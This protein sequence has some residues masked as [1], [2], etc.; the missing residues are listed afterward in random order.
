MACDLV[1]PLRSALVDALLLGKLGKLGT[2]EM[3]FLA[4]RAVGACNT[5]SLL[6]MCAV[7]LKVAAADGCRSCWGGSG[8]CGRLHRCGWN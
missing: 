3:P 4:P 2:A 8:C 5:L 6:L 1:T 7:V